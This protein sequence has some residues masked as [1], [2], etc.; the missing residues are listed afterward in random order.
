MASRA[1]GWEIRS[2]PTTVAPPPRTGE[3]AQGPWSAEPSTRFAPDHAEPEPIT[4]GTPTLPEPVATARTVA[5]GLLFATVALVLAGTVL[6][7]MAAVRLL[8]SGHARL[9]FGDRRDRPDG[10]RASRSRTRHCCS[11]SDPQLGRPAPEHAD[12]RRRRL[13]RL[14]AVGLPAPRGPARDHRRRP[15]RRPRPPPARRPPPPRH[16]AARR[17]S[18]SRRSPSSSPAWPPPRPARPAAMPAAEP[19]TTETGTT[20]RR[21]TP[22]TEATGEDARPAD[23]THRRRGHGQRGPAHPAHRRQPAR[24]GDETTRPRRTAR[25]AR[26]T[27]PAGRRNRDGRHDRRGRHGRRDRS[28]DAGADT[29]GDLGLGAEAG[30]GEFVAA[31]YG[32]LDERR[33]DA[34]WAVAVSRGPDVVRRPRALAQRLRADALEHAARHRGHDAVLRDRDGEARAGRARQGLRGRSGS[35]S[36]GSC[37]ACQGMARRRPTGVRT[38]RKSLLIAHRIVDTVNTEGHDTAALDWPSRALRG[39]GHAGPSLD[40]VPPSAARGHARRATRALTGAK[41]RSPTILTDRRSGR[42]EKSGESVQ[43]VG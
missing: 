11:R 20:G 16:L 22:A 40:G 31:Y 8:S 6:G 9:Q 36:R 33:F 7:T 43:N 12:P 17:H 29:A 3:S 24:I 15:G 2:V 39:P 10:R 34:A 32:A 18:A 41:A 21:E 23:A 28:T 27:R 19:R 14:A 26:T 38:Q 30:P 5:T 4:A 25:P 1:H 42:C 37:G 35:P 13:A